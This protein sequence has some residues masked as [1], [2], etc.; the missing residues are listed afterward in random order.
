MKVIT[1]E[2]IEELSIPA[3]EC[4]SWV[5]YALKN[6]EDC[7]LPAKTSIYKTSPK[8]FFNVMPVIFGDYAS[9]K[10]VTRNSNRNVH[11]DAQILLYNIN[12][13]EC[14][15][16]LDGNWITTMRTGAVAAHTI[17][18][19]AKSDFSEVGLIGCGNT[20]RAAIK[21]LLSKL[22]NRKINLKIFEYKNQHEEFAKDFEKYSNIKITF[23]K[24]YE[25]VVQNSDVV[26]SSVTYFDKDICADE[27]FKQGVLVVPIH[28]RGFSNCD[29]FFDKVFGDDINHINHFKYFDKFKSFNEVAEVV[30]G[31]VPGRQNNL[32]RILTYNVGI[33]LHDLYFASKIYEKSENI[34][35]QIDLLSPQQKFYIR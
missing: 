16:L 5:E 21:I 30:Q 2:D 28:T 17:M 15:A 19:L 25:K 11:L 10:V 1:F 33:G 7:I 20:S 22:G 14:L 4:F 13:S 18:T 27:Y 34:L 6:K 29:L 24:T 26:I 23:V 9:V 32:E 3:E 35:N 8:E 31:K 12:T